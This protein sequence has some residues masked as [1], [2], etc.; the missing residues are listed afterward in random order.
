MVALMLSKAHHQQ[1]GNIDLKM[2]NTPRMLAGEMTPH[3]R[4]LCAVGPCPLL[5]CSCPSRCRLL[6]ARRR[7]KFEGFTTA[8]CTWEG[9][10]ELGALH[11]PRCP[12]LLELQAQ[13]PEV[14]A[15]LPSPEAAG[16]PLSNACQAIPCA[17]VLVIE[18]LQLGLLYRHAA[19]DMSVLLVVIVGERNYKRGQEVGRAWFSVSTPSFR[20][21][22]LSLR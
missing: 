18:L 6:P 10:A 4:L 14:V 12:L 5:T 3:E 22:F 1:T 17:L 13:A 19:A 21:I 8:C 9:G 7:H 16:Q 2:G 11:L 20:P 15:D